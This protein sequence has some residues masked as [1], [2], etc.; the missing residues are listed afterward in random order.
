MLTKTIFKLATL[1]VLLLIFSC[2]DDFE[3][4]NSSNKNSITISE[5]T[6]DDFMLDNIFS[7]VY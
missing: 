3:S 5:K 2:S 7:D 4:T 6:F 1:S